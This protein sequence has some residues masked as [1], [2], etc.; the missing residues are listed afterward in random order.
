MAVNRFS[1]V[2][3]FFLIF[4]LVCP[5]FAADHM[6]SDSDMFGFSFDDSNIYFTSKT[7]SGESIS[8]DSQLMPVSQ[9]HFYIPVSAPCEDLTFFFSIIKNS[10]PVY[11]DSCDYGTISSNSYSMTASLDGPRRYWLGTNLVEGSS[12]RVL[13]FKA[14]FDNLPFTSQDYNRFIRLPLDKDNVSVTTEEPL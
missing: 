2:L 11:Y 10:N 13:S 6:E 5:V 7:L 4:F 14:V 9:I 3:C 1:L 8:V 12:A